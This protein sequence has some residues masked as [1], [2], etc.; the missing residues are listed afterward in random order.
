VISGKL[1]PGDSDVDRYRIDVARAG[2]L[3][4]V[5]QVGDGPATLE[6]EDP[7]GAVVAR[8]DRPGTRN[9]IGLPNVGVTPGRY[10]AIVR[11]RLHPKPTHPGSHKR[12]IEP[13]PVVPPVSY[14]IAADLIGS[15]V[16]G[17]RE[18]DDYRAT[19][20]D[21]LAGDLG[22]GY[23]GWDHDVDVWKL[24]VEGMSGRTALDIDVGP[25]KDVALELQVEDGIGQPIAFRK[26]PRGVAA[27]VHGLVPVV[28]PGGS[29]FH[30]IV[31]RG[32]AGE[33]NP[34]ASYQISA[35]I[36]QIPA[37]GEV[38]PDDTP[39][40][41][42]EVPAGAASV[43]ATWTP[44]DVDC[45]LLPGSPTA[46]DVDV[47]VAPQKGLDLAVEVLADAKVV[48]TIPHARSAT[49]HVVAKLP[50]GARTIVK[51]RGADAS[52]VQSGAYTVAFKDAP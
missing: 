4:V 46:R 52:A 42:F 2:E 16:N 31:V 13:A 25:L 50:A 8:D 35:R 3:R 22:S 7:S 39:D 24:S 9:R 21:I 44:G 40:H 17:E 1:D 37:N 11:G 33:S 29:P 36:V 26:V 6:I 45:F 18:P 47:A 49:D 23:I 41:P 32:E 38:E 12:G 5:V 34:D 14:V 51:V 27:Q 28:P 10:I 30:Y 20:T 43:A 15:E 19:A 48:A